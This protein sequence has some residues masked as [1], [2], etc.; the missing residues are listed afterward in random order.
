MVRP[1]NRD[2]VL[3]SLVLFF[4]AS[5]MFAAIREA[6]KDE[7]AAVTLGAQFAA[8]LLVIG[9]IVLFVRRQR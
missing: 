3:W 7:S 1:V 8:G 2:T 5:I 4:G 9:A 6:T